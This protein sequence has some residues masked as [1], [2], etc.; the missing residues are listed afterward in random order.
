MSMLTGANANVN[1]SI[2][3]LALRRRSAVPPPSGRGGGCFNT[4]GLLKA[5]VAMAKTA[6]IDE[7]PL[8]RHDEAD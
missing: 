7:A 2:K 3:W 5:S 4:N 8:R 1:W 6:S